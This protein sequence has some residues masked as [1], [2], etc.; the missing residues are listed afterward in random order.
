LNVHGVHGSVALW[1][2]ETGRIGRGGK[3]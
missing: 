1:L 2:C 3:C